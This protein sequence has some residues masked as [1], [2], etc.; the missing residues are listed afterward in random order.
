LS[1]I[2]IQVTEKRAC[3]KCGE[4]VALNGNFCNRCGAKQYRRTIN[5]SENNWRLL[6]QAALFFSIDI[7]ICCLCKFAD[8]FK[9]LSWF[10]LLDVLA[11]IITVVFFAINWTENKALLIWRNFSWQKVSAYA[12]IAVAASFLVHYSVG[13]LN[14]VIYSKDEHYFDFVNGNLFGEIFVIF[15]TAIMPALFEELGYRGYMLQ[16]LLKVAEPDQAIYISAFLFAIIHMSFISLFWLIP[17]ALFLG[18]VRIKEGT[19]WYGILI[20]FCFNLTACMFE[21]L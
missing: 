19:L 21:L 8:A 1:A 2:D 7:F 15:F 5:S 4:P 12:A 13:W 16:T 14:V 18:F 20:H 6:K 10:V 3:T 17:F 9:S 11:A